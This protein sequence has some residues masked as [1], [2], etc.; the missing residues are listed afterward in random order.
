MD[1][2]FSNIF[3]YRPYY[4][5]SIPTKMNSTDKHAAIVFILNIIR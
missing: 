1:I 4:L 5:F 3:F 2:F